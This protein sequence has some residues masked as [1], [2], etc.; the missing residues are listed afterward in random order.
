MV[1]IAV[2]PHFT[3]RHAACRPFQMIDA[4]AHPPSHRLHHSFFTYDRL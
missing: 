1:C 4:M 2:M 3:V